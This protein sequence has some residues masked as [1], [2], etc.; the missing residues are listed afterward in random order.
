MET[1]KE[2]SAQLLETMT[3]AKLNKKYKELVAQNELFKNNKRLAYYYI[4]RDAGVKLQ[5]NVASAT[6]EAFPL[7]IAEAFTDEKLNF[8]LSGYLLNELRP[9]MASNS[10]QMMFINIAD[11]T[12]TIA[13]TVFEEQLSQLEDLELQPQDFITLSNLYWKD[14]SSYTPTYGEYSSV[15][16]TEPTLELADVVVNSI[17]E[18]KDKGYYTIKGIVA[19]LPDGSIQNPLHCAMGHWF[20]SLDEAEVGSDSKCVKC[21]DIME[22]EQHLAVTGMVFGDIDAQTYVNISTFARLDSINM[23]DELLLRGKYDEENGV[24]NANAVIHLKKT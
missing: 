8:N 19:D 6:R 20:A 11:D 3:K 14:K 4:A 5:T 17:A 10:K 16:K 9:F 15:T 21:E 12:G 18:F 2:L 7:T 24:F 22:I 1:L 13:I 23:L